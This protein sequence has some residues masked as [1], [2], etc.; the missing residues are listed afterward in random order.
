MQYAKTDTKDITDTISDSCTDGSASAT[1]TAS[2]DISNIAIATA[3]N[4]AG[5]TAQG[6]ATQTA[7]LI[8]PKGFTGKTVL[9]SYTDIFALSLSGVGPGIGKAEACIGFVNLGDRTCH[10]IDTNGTS[11]NTIHG[12][13]KLTKLPVSG[14]KLTIETQAYAEA[15]GTAPPPPTE[16]LVAA[17]AI[18]RGNPTL[19]L[20]KGWKCKY[21][22]GTPCP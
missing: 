17:K 4:G 8:P 22:S 2:L 9:F 15:A 5:A 11:K 13:Y 14:F 12:T 16:P 18:T 6:I 3:Q 20:P 7:T 1:S 10:Y 21:D 19:I